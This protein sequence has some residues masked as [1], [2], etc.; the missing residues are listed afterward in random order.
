MKTLWIN[1][2]AQA[3]KEMIRRTTEIPTRNVGKQIGETKLNPT[4]GNDDRLIK[5]EQ[6]MYDVPISKIRPPPRGQI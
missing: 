4:T 5:E 6:R 2:G 1:I 3:K